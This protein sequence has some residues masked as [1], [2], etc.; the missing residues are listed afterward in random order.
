MYLS[1]DE[2]GLMDEDFPKLVVRDK[3]ENTPDIERIYRT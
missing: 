2:H 3:D 1:A